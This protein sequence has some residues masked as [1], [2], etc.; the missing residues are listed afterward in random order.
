MRNPNKRRTPAG[1]A[2]V[3]AVAVAMVAAAAMGVAEEEKSED[4]TLSAGDFTLKR[5]D[6][7]AY[8][9]PAP[10]LNFKQREVFMRGRVG[11]NQKWVVFPSLGGDWGLGP[12][13]IADRCV[14]CH[15]NAGRGTPPAL[16]TEAPLSL[17]LRLSIPGVDEHGGPKPHPNYGDQFQNQGLE[18][19][20]KDHFLGDRVPPEGALYIDWVEQPMVFADGEKVL[21]RR[22]KIRFEKLNFGPLGEDIQTSLR[23]TQPIFGLGLLEAVS[24]QTVLDLAQQQADQGVHGKP[25]Y[26]WDA[27]HQRVSM[28]RFGWKAN[29]PSVKQQIA[30]AFMGDIGVTSPIYTEE[31]C[32][33]IQTACRAQPPGNRPELVQTSWDELEFWTLG[34]AVPARRDM[35]DAQ[36]QRGAEAFA[37]AR[38]TV[39]HV[40]TLQTGE[41]VRLP[42][43]SHQVFHAY[44]DLLLHDMGDGLAD[45]RPDYQ[46]GPR[47]WR[48]QPLWGLG[49]SQVV[50]GSTAM[51]HDGR[52]RNASEAI[53]WH[54]GEAASAQEAFRNMS[55]EDRAALLK[56][57]DAI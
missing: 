12:T 43:L 47:D 20:D 8:S 44:T 35:Q 54:G 34:L 51:L 46:A 11:F 52:A 42:Q 22:P 27:V 55:R 33:P 32:P 57:L 29:Q 45:G 23:L 28:G 19:K 16:P 2:P 31:N 41:Y 37:A 30:A 1:S 10:V 49:L 9:E 4:P 53:L 7:Q 21:L 48:T 13:F 15:T 38:C 18:G 24:E 14:A 36:V 39:C 5:A 26:V 40:P 6:A 25:N 17:L 56:F 3:L 50:N